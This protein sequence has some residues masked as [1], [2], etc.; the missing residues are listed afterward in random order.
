VVANKLAAY[1]INSPTS[2]KILVDTAVSNHPVFEQ[3]IAGP[4]ASIKRAAFFLTNKSND[5][6]TGLAI[7]YVF[8]DATGQQRGFRY[9]SDSYMLT[10]F[11]PVAKPNATILIGPKVF[12]PEHLADAGRIGVPNFAASGA[13]DPLSQLVAT[14]NHIE[15]RLD[16]V[17]FATGEVI[18]PDTL[19][20]PEEIT[21]RNAAAQEIAQR[22]NDAA[23]RGTPAADAL[24][25]YTATPVRKDDLAGIWKR[26]FAEEALRPNSRKNMRDVLQNMLTPPTFYSS[27]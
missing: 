15:A 3:E 24:S 13:A 16:A 6:I 27:H 9:F 18:G 23:A 10:A 19:K 25:S 7:R 22:L 11:T 26:R 8:T 1:I 12:L 17:I 5:A 20:L 21:A 14:A 4:L 2:T